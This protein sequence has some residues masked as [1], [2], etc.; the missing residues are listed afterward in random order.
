[1]E[2]AVVTMQEI[3]HFVPIGHDSTGKIAGHFE[4]TGIV[5]RCLDRLRLAGVELPTDLFDRSRRPQR[6]R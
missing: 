6:A 5:P 4:P 1:M 2:G 3:F